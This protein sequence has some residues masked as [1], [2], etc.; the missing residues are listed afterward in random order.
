MNPAIKNFVDTT[1]ATL[2]QPKTVADRPRAEA[3][4]NR[5]KFYGEKYA[6]STVM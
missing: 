3:F 4:R 2:A 1:F 6:W 5:Y